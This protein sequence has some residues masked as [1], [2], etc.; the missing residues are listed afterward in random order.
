MTKD[1]V[2]FTAKYS[3]SLK[4]LC[5][6]T[7]T[8]AGSKFIHSLLDDHPNIVCFPRKFNFG[9]F[10]L[11]ISSYKDD[12]AR[13]VDTFLQSYDHFFSGRHWQKFTHVERAAELGPNKDQTFEVDPI[14]FREILY[15]NLENADIT[16]R[17]LFVALHFAYMEARGKSIPDSVLI[18]YHIHDVRLFNNLRICLEDF[19]DTQVLVTTKNPLLSL[20]SV[21]NSMVSQNKLSSKKL[22]IN[23]C[24]TIYDVSDLLENFPGTHIKVI[25]FETLHRNSTEIMTRLCTWLSLDW[26]TSLLSSTIHGKLWWGN[27][28]IP[29][30][31]FRTDWPK[32]TFEECTGLR[33]NDWKSFSY[34]FYDKMKHYGYISAIDEEQLSSQLSWHTLLWPTYSEWCVLKSICSIS[35]WIRVSTNLSQDIRDPNLSHDIHY[36]KNM[37]KH[38][39]MVKLFTPIANLISHCVIISLLIYKVNPISWTYYYLK[40]VGFCLQKIRRN[41]FSNLPDLL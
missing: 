34:L 9:L 25:P 5:L 24:Q 39:S 41:N 30:N 27:G 33:A 21:F 18:F 23:Y 19:P 37:S 12:L 7:V 16:R 8:R 22:Y 6:L 2:D 1:T 13:V 40:R 3:S 38:L 32:Y 35:H 4:V 28:N 17:S 31:G 15:R 36:L 10:W 11:T 29:R 26:N 14:L 20:D